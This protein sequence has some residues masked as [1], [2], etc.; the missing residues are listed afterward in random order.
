MNLVI[1]VILLFVTI[2]S[3]FMIMLT[4]IYIVRRETY[5]ERLHID[6]TD[7]IPFP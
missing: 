2:R 4:F 6:Y 1:V 3:V 5:L 7:M